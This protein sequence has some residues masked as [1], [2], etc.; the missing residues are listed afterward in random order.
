[1]EENVE[2]RRPNGILLIASDKNHV[3]HYQSFCKIVINQMQSLLFVEP[4]NE[5]F[6][7]ISAV[8]KWKF[9]AQKNILFVFAEHHFQD[10]MLVF[11]NEIRCKKVYDL[12][13]RK[14]A[15]DVV[16]NED[17]YQRILVPLLNEI[18]QN[19]FSNI[20]IFELLFKWMNKLEKNDKEFY[21]KKL[22]EIEIYDLIF[23]NGKATE[24]SNQ[25]RIQRKRRFCKIDTDANSEDEGSNND[26][27][28]Q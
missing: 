11:K 19:R 15:K 22:K 20:T 3:F 25:V 28:K 13:Y 16:S 5:E 7:L 2:K 9:I 21:I 26:N 18:I 12:I 14:R 4:I 10:F 27:K 24:D 8:F 1:M 17:I 23:S 6:K